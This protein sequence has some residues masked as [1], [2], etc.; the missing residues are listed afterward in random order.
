MTFM[1]APTIDT[2]KPAPYCMTITFEIDPKDEAEFNE[3]YDKD[4]LPN[5]L[6]LDGVEQI[7]RYKDAKPNDKGHLVYTA[8]YF[9]T[10]AD[11][12]ET[13]E[14]KEISDL[15]RWAPDIRPKIKAR[16]RRSGPVVAAF[17][18]STR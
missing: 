18:K 8:V 5:I 14:W 12:H 9:F 15:G 11:L 16:A 3:V 10:K 1:A 13:P 7:I 4:H 2:T 6:R 17:R